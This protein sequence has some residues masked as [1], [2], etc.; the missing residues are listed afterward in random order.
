[1]PTEFTARTLKSYDVPFAKPVK[2]Y[3]VFVPALTNV[4]PPLLDTSYLVIVAP[5][6]LDGAD[7]LRDTCPFPTIALKF[8]GAAGTLAVVVKVIASL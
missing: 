7:Q 1:L 3:D 6:L 2:V 4:A 8:C 5:P